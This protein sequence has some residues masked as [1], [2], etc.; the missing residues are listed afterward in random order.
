[1][2]EYAERL[3]KLFDEYIRE[4]SMNRLLRLEVYQSWKKL[5][6]LG[7]QQLVMDQIDD[8]VIHLKKRIGDS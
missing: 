2:D 8:V 3:E 7:E 6:Q 5:I 4:H 1:M